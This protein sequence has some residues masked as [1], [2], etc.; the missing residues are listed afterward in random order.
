MTRTDQWGCPIT[1]EP[2]DI[3]AI[4]QVV[5]DYLT[6]SPTIATRMPTLLDA[7]PL[8][9]ATLAMLLT[10]SHRPAQV[11]QARE[12]A[13][14]AQRD[15]TEVSQRERHHLDA[16]VAWADGRIGDVVD[17]F[18][19]AL[20]E[21]PTDLFALRARYLLLF[22][23]GRVP[24]MV[25]MLADARQHWNNDLPLASYLDGMEAFAWEE[26]GEY[27]RAEELG[28]WGVEQEA[29]DLW[30]IH[31]VAHVME[32]EARRDE[33]VAWLDG[34]AG[35]MGG[36]GFA[37]HL[38]WHRAIQLWAI[39]RFD[40]ALAAFDDG[41]YPPRSEEGLDLTNA[42]SL[43]ARLESLGVDV[44]DRWSELADPAASR[45]GQHTQP[46]NDT[47]YALALT[48]AGRL[49]DGRRLIEGMR[50][51]SQGDDSAAAVL[52]TVGVSV[53]EG[54]LAFGLGHWQQ[55]VD[56]FDPVA[57]DVWRL[58]GSNAQRLFYTIVADTARDQ[59]GATA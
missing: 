38:W 22:S 52:R 43:L 25:A 8:A 15:A 53:A 54:M 21:H 47:H 39:G 16:A 4:E 40:E 59:A 36:P 14:G 28:R 20:A 35:V 45:V 11:A 41:V 34:H 19:A 30:A 55:A 37:G 18:G 32:M 57:D 23:S 48:R 5:G 26:S 42:I 9:Q 3:T 27:R 6:M 44:G 13:A 17:A 29:G 50:A 49:D 31:S 10:Q 24:E 46:F 56:K 1:A 12:L 51:W 58:G 2:D 33:G 7:G